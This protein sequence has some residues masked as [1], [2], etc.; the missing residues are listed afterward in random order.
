M[1]NRKDFEKK[2]L[3]KFDRAI[4]KFDR[5]IELLESI[6]VVSGANAHIKKHELRKIA[7]VATNRVTEITRSIKESK[8]PKDTKST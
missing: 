8:P 7:G 2:I 5:A 3:K 6:L 4:E 1:E